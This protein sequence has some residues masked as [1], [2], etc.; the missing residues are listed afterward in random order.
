MTK[1]SCTKNLVLDVL[2]AAGNAELAHSVANAELRKGRRK[3]PFTVYRRGDSAAYWR[4]AVLWLDQNWE[5]ASQFFPSQLSWPE[6]KA[7]IL[8]ERG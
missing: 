6:I 8:K 2:H 3:L 5:Y 1:K 7:E 4:D